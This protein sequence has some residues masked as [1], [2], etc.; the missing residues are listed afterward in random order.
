M[1]ICLLICTNQTNKALIVISRIEDL[2]EVREEVVPQVTVFIMVKQFVSYTCPCGWHH[3]AIN[4]V[5]NITA[6]G[7]SYLSV[8]PCHIPPVEHVLVCVG[9]I[10]CLNST[11]TIFQHRIADGYCISKLPCGSVHNFDYIHIV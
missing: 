10:N 4:M 7:L 9:E 1:L 8:C 6:Q 2:V 11:W 5:N 3:K